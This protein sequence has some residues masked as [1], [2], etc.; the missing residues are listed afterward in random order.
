MTAP[1]LLLVE[2]DERLAELVRDALVRAGWN[3]THC[4]RGDDGEALMRREAFDIVL[5]DGL[6]PGKD[7]FDV[8]IGSS[9]A[10]HLTGTPRSTG[11]FAVEAG[12]R[13]A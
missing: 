9:R 13:A 4:A 7:G 3:V 11:R 2:D 10:L 1:R 12:R 8:R 5:L 6:L